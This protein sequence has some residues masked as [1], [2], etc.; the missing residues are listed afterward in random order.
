M[1]KDQKERA[2]VQTRKL[3][4]TSK[5]SEG[6]EQKPRKVTGEGR[7]GG[8]G[9]GSGGGGSGH[10]CLIQMIKLASTSKAEGDKDQQK[11]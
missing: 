9:A 8:G 6:E 7:R 4:S 10:R 3:A 11:P 2:P 5:K 1:Q